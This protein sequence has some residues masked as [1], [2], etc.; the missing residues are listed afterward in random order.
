MR[1]FTILPCPLGSPQFEDVKE[2]LKECKK[3]GCEY[4]DHTEYDPPPNC[5]L[6]VAALFAGSRKMNE[7][8]NAPSHHWLLGVADEETHEYSGRCSSFM[9]KKCTHLVTFTTKYFRREI[10]KCPTCRNVDW[11]PVEIEIQN[12]YCM[13]CKHTWTGLPRTYCPE[14]GSAAIITEE[15]EDG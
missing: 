2:L 10:G 1:Q 9:C 6:L 11:E 8:K 14:C 12:W 13:N 5:T 4:P 7:W 3:V 15:E